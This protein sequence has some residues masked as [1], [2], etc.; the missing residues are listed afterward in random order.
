MRGRL[1]KE[2]SQVKRGIRRGRGEDGEIKKIQRAKKQYFIIKSQFILPTLT[3][4]V[5]LG[6][7][8]KFDVLPHISKLTSQCLNLAQL[9][10][11]SANLKL[12]QQ[13]MGLIRCL[14]P[15]QPNQNSPRSKLIKSLRHNRHTKLAI[16]SF[17]ID[18]KPHMNLGLHHKYQLEHQIDREHNCMCTVCG[19]TPFFYPFL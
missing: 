19:T 4:Q 9:A 10:S 16:G 13:H 7:K 12:T 5:L 2:R 8:Y 15:S 11:K 6:I 14:S 18:D 1:L 17:A 3:N